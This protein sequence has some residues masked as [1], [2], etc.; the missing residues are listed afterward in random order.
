[1]SLPYMSDKS[2][3]RPT[4]RTQF[5]GLNNNLS[6]R[7][8]EIVWMENMS[9]REFPL[10]TPRN[11]RAH[12]QNISA[13]NGLGAGDE[14]WWVDG[15]DFYYGGELKGSLWTEAAIPYDMYTAKRHFALMGNLV[16]IFPDKAYYDIQADSFGW[17]EEGIAHSGVTKFAGSTYAGVPAAA[18]TIY[19]G[20]QNSFA[21]GDAVTISG[22]S[23]C[24]DNNKTVIIREI[25]S[26]EI[27]FYENTFRVYPKCSFKVTEELPAGDYWF[28]YDWEGESGPVGFT[29]LEPAVAGDELQ[30][31]PEGSTAVYLVHENTSTMLFIKAVQGQDTFLNG[32]KGSVVNPP[33]VNHVG[34]ITGTELQ[35]GFE[36]D[37]VYERGYISVTR[38]APDLDFVCVNENRLWGCKG[39]TI[40]ASAL[41]DPFNFNVFDGLS[42]DSWQ[43]AVPD[44]GDFTACVSYGG[45]P[46]FF[47]ENSICKVQG[48]KPSNFQWTLSS[49]FGV[50]EGS[51]WSLAVAGETLFYLSRAGI[52]SYNGGA[53]RV[54]SEALGA[55]TRWAEASGG[56][57]GIRYYVSLR[58]Y[59]DSDVSGL[60]VF[61]T[62][63]GVWH[64]EDDN[65]GMFAFCYESLYMLTNNGDLY[66]LDG[67]TN[68]GTLEDPITWQVAFADSD[69][70]YETTDS[71]SQNKKGGPLRI[72]I[73][74]TLAEDST[75]EVKIKYDDGSTKS[76]GTITSTSSAKKKTYILPLILRRCD[77]YQLSMDGYGDAVIYSIAVE[78]YSGSQF[79]GS[80][81]VSLPNQDY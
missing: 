77:H 13:P 22:C 54:I 52:C 1:M 23:V 55:N 35:F 80:S 66:R 68:Y 41:G 30:F 3:M 72:L 47:K 4:V 42:T 67:D 21:V 38:K 46:I 50:K 28:Q 18:N 48:D 78:R 26:G 53:P 79:Q 59:D 32:M 7:D 39:D 11:Q 56:S 44:E 70:F 14:L 17:I 12:I 2:I 24:P 8:G 73:R 81:S 49:R 65:W 57:D 64:R 51:S 62:R 6:A 36:P 27:R 5:G 31:S 29:L 40:Y 63:Y 20:E 19:I 58:D 34:E 10:L 37:S 9:S 25:G 74:A 75:I 45:Y 33:L 71:N 76:V 43:S 61:D 60:Y 69:N 15:T 16:L